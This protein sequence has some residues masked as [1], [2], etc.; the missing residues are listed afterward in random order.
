METRLEE[1][2]VNSKFEIQLREI[3]TAAED[4]AEWKEVDCGPRSTGTDET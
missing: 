2:Y 4:R 3:E 1:R